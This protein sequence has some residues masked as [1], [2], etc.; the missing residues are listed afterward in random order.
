[1][2]KQIAQGY[3]AIGKQ[4]GMI[5]G[6]GM[7]KEGGKEETSEHGGGDSGELAFMNTDLSPTLRVRALDRL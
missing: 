5:T 4:I 3:E 7:A 6:K 2:R 1:L